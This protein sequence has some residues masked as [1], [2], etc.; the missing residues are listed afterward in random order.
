MSGETKN[1]NLAVILI[2]FAVLIVGLVLVVVI[3]GDNSSKKEIAGNSSVNNLLPF[4][5]GLDSLTA[6][7]ITVYG[8]NDSLTADTIITHGIKVHGTYSLTDGADAACK[9]IMADVWR[10]SKNYPYINKINFNIYLR[11]ID[12]YGKSFYKFGFA[13]SFTGLD[14]VRRFVDADYYYNSN[15]AYMTELRADLEDNFSIY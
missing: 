3:G 2:I 5:V 4:N 14:D 7:T 13:Y 8:T 12:R 15:G 1:L 10:I 11:G 9:N 6:D